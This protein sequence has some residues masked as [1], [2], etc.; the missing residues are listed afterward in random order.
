MSD[1]HGAPLHAAAAA[2]DLVTLPLSRTRPLSRAR[3]TGPA[4]HPETACGV[5]VAAAVEDGVDEGLVLPQAPRR[6]LLPMR[7][8][9]CSC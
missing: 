4:R 7:V 1:L 8:R 6:K 9:A 2:P 3:P 5:P